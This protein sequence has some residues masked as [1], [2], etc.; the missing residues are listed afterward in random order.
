MKE[1]QTYDIPISD[2]VKDG[3]GR[4]L[5]GLIVAVVFNPS[6]LF[7][8]LGI[9]NVIEPRRLCEIQTESHLMSNLY[10]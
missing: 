7:M 9:W 6:I 8:I 1:F 4:I 2:D 5:Y 3:N 10:K